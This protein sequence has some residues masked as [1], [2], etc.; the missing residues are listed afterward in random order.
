[1]T[2]RIPLSATRPL[3]IRPISLKGIA[4]TRNQKWNRIS[5]RGLKSSA[6]FVSVAATGSHVNGDVCPIV[7]I[8]RLSEQRSGT[9]GCTRTRTIF[10]SPHPP[11]RRPLPIRRSILKQT[12]VRS[13]RIDFTHADRL[14]GTIPERA[15]LRGARGARGDGGKGRDERKAGDPRKL[16]NP[17]EIEMTRA[18][19]QTARNVTSNRCA[20]S[21]ADS[22]ENVIFRAPI[23]RGENSWRRFA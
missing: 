14:T 13:V 18:A 12:F 6:R 2:S 15:N 20:R 3:P 21:A 8:S 10:V 9:A 7:R 22:S 23:W 17:D 11:C 1:M 5:Y 16:A 4:P 19:I